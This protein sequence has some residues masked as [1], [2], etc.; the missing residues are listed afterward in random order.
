MYRPRDSQAQSYSEL[1]DIV[2][3]AA[4]TQG[5]GAVVQDVFG[6]Y[7]TAVTAAMIADL[8]NEVTVIYKHEQ[9]LV[10]KVTGTGETI[11][12]GQKVYAT[13]ASNFQSVTANP[14]GVIG[15][16]YYFVGWAKEDA[17]ANQTTV[18]IKFDGS[19]YNHAD[20]AA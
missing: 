12:S 14:A 20:H 15:T 1:L 2:V 8:R 16:N 19:E 10:D 5:F 3:A 11:T 13:L 4:V 18:L 17:T 9:V 7:L 6:Y